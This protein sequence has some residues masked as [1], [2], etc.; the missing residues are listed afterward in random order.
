M[1]LS[2]VHDGWGAA[3]LQLAAEEGGVYAGRLLFRCRK[4]AGPRTGKGEAGTGMARAVK[5]KR[6]PGWPGP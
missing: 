6:E 5:E 2:R 4:G 3:G 1:C